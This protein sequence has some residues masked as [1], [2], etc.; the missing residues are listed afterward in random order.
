MIG[1]LFSN[2]VWDARP[3][4]LTGIQ[5][6]RPDYYNV[7]LLGTFGGPVKLPRLQNRLNVFVGFQRLADDN[8]LTQ[9]GLMPTPLERS[10]NFSQSRDASGRPVQIIDPLTGLPF[11]GNTIPRDRISPQASSLLGYYPQPTRESD[12]RYNYEVPILSVMRQ[13]SLQS[14]LTQ[15]INQRNQVFGNVSYQRTTTNANNLFG[16]EDE[17][18]SSAVDAQVNWN[19][20]IAQLMSMRLR[21]QFTRQ[22]N[23]T[24]PYFAYRTNVSGDAGINGNN[25]EPVNWGPPSLSFASGIAGLNDGL[26]RFTRNQTNAVGGDSFMSRGRHNFTIGGDLKRNQVDILAQQDPRG[27]F[28]F[29]GALTGS[30]FADFLLGVPATSQIAY[31]N[32]D[33]YLRG[34]AYDAY[35]TDDWRVG[36]SLTVTAGVRWE[37]E[38]PLSER[39]DRLVN[40]DIGPGFT[41]ISPIVASEPTGSLTGETLPSVVDAVGLGRPAAAPGRCV[42]AGAG[43]VCRGAC[44]IRNLPQHER[45]SIDRH[46]DGAAAAALTRTEHR[47]L[48]RQSAHARKWI[49]RAR[50]R[51]A[52]HVRRRSRFPHRIRS[53]LAG[54]DPARPARV[55]DGQRDISR[56]QGKRSHPGVPA[57]HVSSRLHRPVRDLSLRLRVSAL[58]RHLVASRGS[59]AGASPIAQRTHRHR[60]IHAREG[61]RRCRVV[62]GG[63]FEQFS[64]RAELARPRGRAWPLELRSA[65]SAVGAVPVHDRR[66]RRRWRAR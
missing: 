24:T 64:V 34:F 43:I 29:T 42:A 47:E 49:R 38:S 3:Y 60:A 6:P 53:Q 31:G 65:S 30:D 48:A 57:Q 1:S 63:E 7:H 56:H 44:G 55:A 9:P 28:A 13:E 17:N 26:P 39:Y 35:V 11:P 14:R 21:Y 52:Q 8:A 10:G 33:K 41:S 2:S 4:P 19:H 25:Q 54:L 23:E 16:F 22:T 27:G 62:C 40:L 12:G 36:P 46:A 15:N 37:Y 61:H 59:T 20:R 51:D 66:R 45:L 18:G 32:A 50:G 5:T 58:E